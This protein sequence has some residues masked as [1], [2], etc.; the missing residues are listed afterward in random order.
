MKWNIAETDKTAQ[1]VERI[2]EIIPK[3]KRMFMVDAYR[4]ITIATPV[5]TG[6][7]K[8]GWNCS[9]TDKDPTIPPPGTYSLDATRANKTFTLNI[10]WENNFYITNDVPYIGRLNDG[11]SRKAPARFFELSVYNA[12]GKLKLKYGK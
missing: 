8:W 3:A 2:Q 5:L 6:R 4:Q 7:A 9:V 1:F 12:L 11:Y 10:P